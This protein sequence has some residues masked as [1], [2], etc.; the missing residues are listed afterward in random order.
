MKEHLTQ[1]HKKGWG[2]AE[3]P[4][5]PKKN[6]PKSTNEVIPRRQQTQ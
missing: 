1:Q 2:G 4:P 5:S 3:S 6:H